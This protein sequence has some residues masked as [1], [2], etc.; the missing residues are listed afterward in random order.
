[1]KGFQGKR[2][3]VIVLKQYLAIP[4]CALLA[5]GGTC[6]TADCEHMIYKPGRWALTT[7]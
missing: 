1:M 5:G 4:V 3:I 6:R 7:I 2:V